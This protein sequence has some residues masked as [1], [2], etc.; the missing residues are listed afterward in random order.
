MLTHM[1]LQWIN[2]CF[3]K[4][5][6]MTNLNHLFHGCISNYWEL[7]GFSKNHGTLDL[8]Q[9]KIYTLIISNPPQVTNMFYHRH[10]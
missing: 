8:N 4:P 2:S 6:K 9:T 1:M 10:K 3:F 5:S 7:P